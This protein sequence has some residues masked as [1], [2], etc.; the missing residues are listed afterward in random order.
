ML[1]LPLS[2]LPLSRS[3]LNNEL[4]KEGEG[5]VANRGLITSYPDNK[6]LNENQLFIIYVTDE[7]RRQYDAKMLRQAE[8]VRGAV[9]R[10]STER[11]AARVVQEG[12]AARW[13]RHPVP[14]PEQAVCERV[15]RVGDAQQRAGGKPHHDHQ[16]VALVPCD[17]RSGLP[18]TLPSGGGG[19]LC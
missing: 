18:R 1:S 16:T 7:V 9:H 12:C 3:E 17:A 11:A 8:Q 10:A 2:S 13:M 14:R 19:P 6:R 15:A 5:L 4:D